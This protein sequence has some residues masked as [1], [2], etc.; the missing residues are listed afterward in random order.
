MVI[1]IINNNNRLKSESRAYELFLLIY[2]PSLDSWAGEFV[3]CIASNLTSISA[4][5]SSTDTSASFVEWHG[6]CL[7]GMIA[8]GLNLN[9]V[10]RFCLEIRQFS[11]LESRVSV[12]LP[13]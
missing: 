9:A 11:L 1:M 2:C 6:H 3:V 5:I 8:A 10:V 4:S 7:S 13:V 12:A